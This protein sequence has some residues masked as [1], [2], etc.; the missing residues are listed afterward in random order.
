[1]SKNRFQT[2]SGLQGHLKSTIMESIQTKLTDICIEVAKRHIQEKVYNRYQPGE[3]SY[4]RTFELLN[5]VTVGNLNIG[6]KYAT[7]EIYMDSEKI[8]PYERNGVHG[9][10]GWNSHADVYG[11]D[12]SEYIPMWI[13]K[14]TSGS[15]HDRE[16]AHYMEATHHE[17]SGGKLA[18]ALE[19][20]LRKEGWKIISV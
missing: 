20:A 2:V 3:D 13:E 1:M 17:L 8:N 7:F 4:D 19:D 16:G 14:G 15:L 9:Y 10:G 12:M 11:L 6:T 5:S 18:Q